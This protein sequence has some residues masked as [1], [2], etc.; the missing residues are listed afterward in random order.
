MDR[1]HRRQQPSAAGDVALLRRSRCGA[2]P[3]SKAPVI[4]RLA[5]PDGKQHDAEA[6]LLNGDGTPMIV[7][8]ERRRPSVY[9][10]DGALKTDNTKGVPLK[11]VGDVHPAE[12]R[13]RANPLAFL[14][15]NAITGGA[16]LARRRQGRASAPTADAYECDVQRTAT[17]SGAIT[18][19]KPR[20]RR[21]PTSRRARRSPTRPTASTSSPSPTCR[22]TEAPLLRY[23]PSH[24]PRASGAGAVAADA[25]GRQRG[26]PESLTLQRHHLHGRRASACSA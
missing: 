6:L 23:T 18:T 11:Q 17:S 16:A 5:Y 1:R 7:T 12:D 19:G 25:E 2:C 9:V 24:A 4:H 20:S 10:A 22:P 13:R 14:G 3:G 26:R 8:K 15:R 21:C